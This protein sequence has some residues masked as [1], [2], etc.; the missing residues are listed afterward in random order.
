MSMKDSGSAAQVHKL[1]EHI[2][3]NNK[4]PDKISAHFR[5]TLR[6]LNASHPGESGIEFGKSELEVVDTIKR[7]LNGND[8]KLAKFSSAYIKLRR[9]RVLKNYKSILALFILLQSDE[10]YQNNNNNH[11]SHQPF[12]ILPRKEVKPRKTTLRISQPPPPLPPKPEILS[13][14]PSSN[15]LKDLIRELIFVFQGIE[16][17]IIVRDPDED[18]YVITPELRSKY[19]EPTHHRVKRLGELGWLFNKIHKFC[20]SQDSL[21]VN[22]LIGQ[23]YVAALKEELTEYYR[24]LSVLEAQGEGL[25]LS[26]LTVWTYEPMERMK[27]LAQ[28]VDTCRDAKGGALISSIYGFVHHGNPS[29]SAAAKNILISVCRPIYVMLL[30]WVADGILEDPFNEFF[31]AANPKVTAE[32]LWEEKIFHTLNY[33]REVCQ[34]SSPISGRNVI[35]KN[36]DQTTPENLFQDP[37]DN[38]LHSAIQRAYTDTSNAVLSVLFTRYKFLDHVTAMRKY[39]LL[40]QGDVIRYL[41]E[42]LESELDKPASSLYP[43]NLSGILESAVRATNAQFEDPDILDRLDVRLLEIQPGDTGWDVFSLDYKVS[44]PIG[45]VFFDQIP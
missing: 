45:T 2:L 32:R 8:E 24:L 4:D 11:N 6:V 25:T 33:L 19:P 3:G 29:L 13:L 28:M 22:G 41:L 38:L 14:K 36:L 7:L 1:I 9:S 42:L 18:C 39:L 17:K 15:P 20:E 21:N 44:G 30:K 35:K 16:G 31:I 26:Q 34:D 40:G 37:H 23:S 27:F 43:H 12:P 10:P 5:T